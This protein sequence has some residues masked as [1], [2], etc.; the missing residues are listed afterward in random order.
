MPVTP[1][2]MSEYQRVAELFA[3]HPN[4]VVHGWKSGLHLGFIGYAYRFAWWLLADWNPIFETDSLLHL[5]ILLVP[6]VLLVLTALAWFGNLRPR[7]DQDEVIVAGGIALIAV[8]PLHLL[9]SYRMYRAVG[10]P[11]LDAFPR[12]Y[13][14][15]ALSLIPIAVCWSIT[16]ARELPQ[17]I[18]IPALM[19]GLA[20]VPIAMLAH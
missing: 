19:P 9:F 10:S 3:T 2:F 8:M 4:A 13:L 17:A 15:L 14:P 18:L 7:H 11:P 5:A 6:L 20:A 12:Y 16:R 1:G